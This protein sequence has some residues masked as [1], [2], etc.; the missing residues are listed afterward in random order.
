MA[1]PIADCVSGLVARLLA[2]FG[3]SSP[4]RSV[5]APLRLPGSAPTRLLTPARVEFCAPVTGA[6]RGLVEALPVD[7]PANKFGAR[8]V[9]PLFT[10]SPPVTALP[11]SLSWAAVLPEFAVKAG[12]WKL[13]G[14]VSEELVPEPVLSL[15]PLLVPPP[16]SHVLGGW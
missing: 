3:L 8:P 15:L 4:W 7:W 6:T 5:F 1:A 11:I 13:P 9:T 14:V 12:F 2:K 16:I 10:P